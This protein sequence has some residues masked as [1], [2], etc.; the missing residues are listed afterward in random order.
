[1]STD[2]TNWNCSDLTTEQ[3]AVENAKLEKERILLAEKLDG[4][5]TYT[6]I[7]DV[8]EA[9]MENP[10]LWDDLENL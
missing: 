4:S 5:N 2:F 9:L 6:N 8:N 10:S 1:M 7:D 3:K